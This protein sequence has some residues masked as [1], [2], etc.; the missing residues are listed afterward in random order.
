MSTIVTLGHGAQSATPFGYNAG[1]TSADRGSAFFTD[2]YTL[3]PFETIN[4]PLIDGACGLAKQTTNGSSQSTLKTKDIFFQTE[5]MIVSFAARLKVTNAAATD[6]LNLGFSQGTTG[7]IGAQNEAFGFSISNNATDKVTVVFD[8][9]KTDAEVGMS[10]GAQLPSDFV[11]TDFHVYGCELIRQNGTNTCNWFVDGVKVHTVV[12]T[13]D[14]GALMSSL[15]M[16]IW[17]IGGDVQTQFATI[18]WASI[19]LPRA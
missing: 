3:Q 8:D 5:G 17:S 13:P 15:L 2:F 1:D 10:T 9:T 12:S 11:A 14:A 16:G 4:W 7:T 6:S 18:D 19:S